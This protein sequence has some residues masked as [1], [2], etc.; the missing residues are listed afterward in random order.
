MGTVDV[1]SS[2]LGAARSG[3]QKRAGMTE[4]TT[5]VSP[6]QH[7]NQGCTYACC[8][9]CGHLAA[10]ARREKAMF[11]VS[12]WAVEMSYSLLESDLRLPVRDGGST[13][14]RA[15]SGVRAAPP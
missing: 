8:C 2:R 15:V 6:Q 14:I 1:T 7:R 11:S 12:T 3:E 10:K 4:A 5:V 9:A 13:K